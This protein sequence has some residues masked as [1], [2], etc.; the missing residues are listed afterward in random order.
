MLQHNLLFLHST[1]VYLFQYAKRS[2]GA[3]EQLS[4]MH[5]MQDAKWPC[6]LDST[7][8]DLLDYFLSSIQHSQIS[9][10]ILYIDCLLKILIQKTD[11]CHVDTCKSYSF[12]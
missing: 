5:A 2:E 12:Q 6:C 10:V 3:A 7:L 8:S 9:I 4:C 1:L 11:S